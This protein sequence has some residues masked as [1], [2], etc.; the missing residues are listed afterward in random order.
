MRS[1]ASDA[2]ALSMPGSAP[3]RRTTGNTTPSGSASSAASRCSGS[4][5]WWSL[6]R[7]SRW[8]VASASAARWVKL[9][10]SMFALVCR[11]LG[12]SRRVLVADDGRGVGDQV[13]AAR[14][15]DR[16]DLLAVA[17][18]LG[19][20]LGLQGGHRGLEP[21]DLLGEGDHPPHTFQVHAVV[22]QPLDLQ[23]P[24]DVPLG[25]AAGVGGGPLGPDQPL[26]LVDAQ[27]LGVDPG[28]LGRDRD[29]EPG[30]APLVCRGPPP[31]PL[32]RCRGGSWA[33]PRTA[34]RTRA[35]G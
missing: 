9:F 24:L 5:R 10:T 29:H 35:A 34:T 27:G 1:R 19:P 32:S 18:G 8:A 12:V 22:G 28:Q 31:L 21:L 14:A 26:P 11:G 6:E 20:Q 30:P 33:W 17:A 16:L 25:V 3:A 23:Q 13:A 7:A 4:M 2:L 15:A